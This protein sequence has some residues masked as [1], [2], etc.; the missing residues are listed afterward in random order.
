M[1]LQ[2][3]AS[4]LPHDRVVLELGADIEAD[5]E[6]LEACR[7]LRQEGFSLAIDD[8]VRTPAI[9]PLLPFVS[10][11]KVDFR[12]ATSA[13]ARQSIGAVTGAG[14]PLMIAKRIETPQEFEAAVTEGFV[15]FQGYFLGHPVVIA[16]RRMA[17][18]D[19]ARLQLLRALQNPQLSVAQI[20]DLVKPDAALCYQILQTVNSA[21]FAQHQRVHSIRQ[22]LLLLGRDVVRRWVSVWT[23]AS[24]GAKSHPELITLSAIRA[25]CC[26]VLG[27]TLGGDALAAEGF[28]VGLCSLLD[29]ILGVPMS[30]IIEKVPLTEDSRLALAG[31]QNRLRGML[32]CAVSYE[33]GDWKAC[34]ASAERIGLDS[35]ILPAAYLD[36]LQWMRELQRF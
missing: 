8:F 5:D 32:D 20:E 17:G 4:V 28:L 21:A 31:G 7:A 6:V 15:Y 29:T 18:A 2:G 35:R 3:L 34:S 19:L 30:T 27:E 22:A 23:L 14:G 9:E 25:R 1:L 36:A 24:L 33:R 12:F 16:G 10:Y 26:E 13:T 11:L